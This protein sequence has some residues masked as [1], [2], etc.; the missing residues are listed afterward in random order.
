MIDYI[1]SPLFITGFVISFVTSFIV[2]YL[3]DRR[4]L[5]KDKRKIEIQIKEKAIE[6]YTLGSWMQ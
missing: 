2:S 6:N 1:I 4:Q 5:G 3:I